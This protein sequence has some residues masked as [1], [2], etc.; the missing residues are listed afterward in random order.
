M[1]E[2]RYI[3]DQEQIELILTMHQLFIMEHRPDLASKLDRYLADIAHGYT[4]S[5]T[6][7]ERAVLNE[8]RQE[9]ISLLKQMR[10]EDRLNEKFIKER[11]GTIE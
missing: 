6:K 3:L 9:Y 8:I 1:S 4:I 11:Y 5:A 2:L 10:I 7:A